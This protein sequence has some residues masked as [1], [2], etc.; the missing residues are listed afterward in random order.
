[1]KKNKNIK[2]LLQI[3]LKNGNIYFTGWGLCIFIHQLYY[4]Q[5]ISDGEYKVLYKFIKKNRPK[6]DSPHYSKIN[7]G[8][9]FYWTMG[10]WAPRKRWIID[11]IKNM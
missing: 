6:P 3:V 4:Q 9:A 10:Q 1:M 5:K 8:S 2:E 11:Q 7:R